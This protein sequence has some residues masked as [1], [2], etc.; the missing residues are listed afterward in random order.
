MKFWRTAFKLKTNLII[1]LTA[2]LLSA[3]AA[4]SAITELKENFAE[5]IIMWLGLPWGIPLSL[6]L[7]PFYW[8]NT[9]QYNVINVVVLYLPFFINVFL[10]CV[11]V[12]RYSIKKSK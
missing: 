10:A 3:L 12:T 1:V 11:I 6:V 8:P 7:L 5:I 9:T 2:I 4:P